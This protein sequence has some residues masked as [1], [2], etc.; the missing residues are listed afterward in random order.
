MLNPVNRD[1]TNF[2]GY[3]HPLKTL[4]KKGKM[5]SV[6][7]GIYG[8]KIDPDTVSLEHLKP[9]SWGG[10]TEYSNLAL[11]N[12]KTNTA[13]GSKPLPDVL[14]W[15]MLE[16]YL[17]QFNFK[18]K[19]IFNGYEYQEKIRNTCE[20]LGVVRPKQNESLSESKVTKKLPKKILR[21]L[22]NKAKKDNIEN[23]LDIQA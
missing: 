11:A 2:T 9:H 22:R 23:K 8:E 6:K 10:R 5:P 21:S 15:G 18:I 14:S 17:K 19:N 3:Q 16:R 20:R 13:R 7:R 4:F 1:N 12:K